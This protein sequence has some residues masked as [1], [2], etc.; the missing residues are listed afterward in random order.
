MSSWPPAQPEKTKKETASAAA[1]F[2]EPGAAAYGAAPPASRLLRIGK[3][4][5]PAGPA[6]TPETTAAPDGRPKGQ[7]SSLPRRH[8]APGTRPLTA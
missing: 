7:A 2:P 6:L 1:E 4:T 8:I 3:P 5:G